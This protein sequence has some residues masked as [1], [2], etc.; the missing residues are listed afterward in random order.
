MFEHARKGKK[1][2]KETFFNFIEKQF[3]DSQP[4]NA[5][6]STRGAGRQIP[7][8]LGQATEKQ[9][10][11]FCYLYGKKGKIAKNGW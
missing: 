5:L 7:M 8:V 4:E 1:K 3:A 9:K 2:E 10:M 11:R 6:V